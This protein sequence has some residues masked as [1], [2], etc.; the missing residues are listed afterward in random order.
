MRI[1]EI[2]RRKGGGVVTIAPDATVRELLR[3]L[4]AH[5]VGAVV[6]SA[7]GAVIS[8]IVSERDIVRRLHG[9]GAPLLDASV[10]S[11]MTAA[12]HTC[13]PDDRVETLKATMTE[14]RIRHLP[15]VSEGRMI[16]IV[17]IGDVVKSQISELETEREALVRYLHG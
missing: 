9:A 4:S 11:I 16:G 1:S 17:S 8:G 15:V 5:N 13:S 3:V 6:V 12:V 14:H 7:D 10:S 2:L